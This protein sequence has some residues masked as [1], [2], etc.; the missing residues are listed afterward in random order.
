MHSGQAVISVGIF[1]VVYGLI[2]SEKIHRAV[3][4]LAGAV[5]V[6]VLG[7]LSQEQA[8]EGIDFNTI[9]LLV[10]MMIIV[11]IARRSGIFE[12][13]AIKAVKVSRGQP[14]RIMVFLT[15]ITALLSALLD[16]VTTVL[17]IIPVTFS[18]A[19]SLDIDPLPLLLAEVIGSNIGGTATLIGDPPNILIGSATHLSFLDFILNLA[20]AV[21]VVLI[22]TLVLLAM[23]YRKSMDVAEEK[24]RTIVQMDELAAIKDYAL[25]KK[26]LAVLTLTMAGFCLHQVLHLEAATVA[27]AGAVLLMIV[28]MEQPE[29][30]LLS[31]EWPTLFFFI[32]LFVL[33]ESL[34]RVGVIDSLARKTLEATHGNYDLTVLLVL[35]VSGIAS[36]FVDNIPFVTAMIPLLKS[37]GQMAAMPMEPLWW[38]LSLGACLGGNGTLIGASA[39][40]VV[41][42]ISEKQ[43]RPISFMEYTKI[44]FPMMLVSLLVSTA[45]IYLRY[46]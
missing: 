29:D 4:S 36:A 13:L 34:V 5:A 30:V 46:L 20:P 2:I 31:V 27:L 22:M 17:L 38:A 41:A 45:Y 19:N 43:G 42:G 33:V 10:G 11:G 6:V 40:V 16:N 18:V 23:I 44:G 25:L 9:G 8:V 37:M 7:V 12:Y 1:L 15:V 14:L 35:W 21:A 3:I 24:K 32:G 26:S 28:T 39:N